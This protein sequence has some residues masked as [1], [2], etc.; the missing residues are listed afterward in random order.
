MF[1]YSEGKIQAIGT[2]T[3]VKAKI[4]DWEFDKIIDATGKSIIPGEC[5][6]QSTYWLMQDSTW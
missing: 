3:E 2:D 5:S 1:L 4:L 6:K